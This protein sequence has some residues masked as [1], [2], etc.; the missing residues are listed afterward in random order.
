MNEESRW[1]WM[2]PYDTAHTLPPVMIL[3]NGRQTEILKLIE[4]EL[5]RLVTMKILGDYL[6]C[7]PNTAMRYHA[8]TGGH[9]MFSRNYFHHGSETANPT[10]MSKMRGYI[11]QGISLRWANENSTTIIC[12]KQYHVASCGEMWSCAAKPQTASPD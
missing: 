8:T 7:F 11:F 4:Q 9:P 1:A 6:K 10:K 12:G 2:I 3:Q 5:Y